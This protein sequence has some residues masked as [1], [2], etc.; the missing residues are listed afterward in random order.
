MKPR[1]EPLILASASRIRLELLRRA[2]L[3]VT[4]EPAEIDEAAVKTALALQGAA[5]A[6][7]ARTLARAKSATISA[8]RPGAL[9]IG[10]DQILELDGLW[11]DKPPDLETARNQLLRLAGRAHRLVTAVSVRLAGAELWDT[12]DE[13]VLTMHPLDRSA[14]DAYLSEA[15]PGALQSVGA[16]QLE[17]LGVQ[18]FERVEGD[19][20]TILGLPLLPLLGFLRGR[21][22]LPP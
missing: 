13:A 1:A 17:A 9:V 7:A 14:I 2:G 12:V 15:G 20:F 10:A 5:T 16:Y 11:Y 4:A 18:L 21:G 3:V 6:E 19:F 22:V 8:R